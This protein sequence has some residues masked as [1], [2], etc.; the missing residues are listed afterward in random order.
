V[1]QRISRHADRLSATV[2]GTSTN[3]VASSSAERLGL[4][5]IGMFELSPLGLVLAGVGLLFLF[6]LAPRLLP[7]YP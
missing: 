4:A 1:K 7:G 6:T 3:L 2:I 5:P